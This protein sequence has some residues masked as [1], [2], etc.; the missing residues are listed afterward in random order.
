MIA[1]R[2]G[3]FW[4][5]HVIRLSEPWLPHVFMESEDGRDLDMLQFPDGERVKNDKIQDQG[6]DWIGIG[7]SDVATKLSDYFNWIVLNGWVGG[8]YLALNGIGYYHPIDLEPIKENKQLSS[9][10]AHR[11]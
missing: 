11:I 9:A 8:R 4:H 1:K 10:L 2:R 7:C 3:W 5:N 6:F